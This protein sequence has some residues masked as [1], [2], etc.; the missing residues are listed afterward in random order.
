MVSLTLLFTTMT[1]KNIFLSL[2]A[3]ATTCSVMFFVWIAVRALWYAPDTEI[4]VPS[5]SVAIS[6]TSTTSSEPVRLLIPSLNINANVQDVGITKSGAMGTP[7]NFTD[8]A[9]YKYGPMPGA[10]GSAVIDGHVDNG[11]AL[12]GVFKHLA[13]IKIGDNVTVVEKDGSQK[14]F[15]VTDIKSYPYQNT[16]SNIIFDHNTDGAHLNLI[17]CEGAWV[18]AGKTYDHRLVVYTKLTS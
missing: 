7:S 5:Q 10:P 6:S 11:L 13:D 4:A 8:V 14:Q 16:P 15:V 18:P 9:W 2:V 1:R 3:L 12:A 17:T